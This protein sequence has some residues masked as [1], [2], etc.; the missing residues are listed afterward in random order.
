MCLWQKLSQKSPHFVSH[1]YSINQ[2]KS[3]YKTVSAHKWHQ[4][5][6]LLLSVYTTYEH[7]HPFFHYFM[8]FLTKIIR[9]VVNSSTTNTFC[10]NPNPSI[11]KIKKF[12]FLINYVCIYTS[13]H[14]EIFQM[15]FQ[16]SN[17]IRGRRR[18]ALVEDIAS[19]TVLRFAKK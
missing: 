19:A 13:V 1:F 17:K 5:L 12:D 8:L 16:F 9:E 14:R 7:N 15:K 6:I 3:L 10:S 2:I 11:T 4:Q 18:E